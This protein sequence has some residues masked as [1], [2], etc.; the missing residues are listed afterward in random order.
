MLVLSEPNGRVAKALSSFPFRPSA[1]SSLFLLIVII[2]TILSGLYY[3]F[4]ASDRF[5]VET[6][7]IVRSV[8]GSQTGGLSAL[9]RTFGIMRAEDELYAVIDFLQSRDAA[10]AADEAVSLRQIWGR[11]EV[12]RIARYP[13]W[14]NFWRE[15]NFELVYEYYLDRVE[16]WYQDRGGIITLRVNAFTP[17]DAQ[18]L[19]KSLLQ[20][21]EKLINRMNERANKDAVS[22]AEKELNRAKAMVVDAQQKITNFRNE[23]LMLDPLAD[24]GKDP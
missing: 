15:E 7:F 23:E 1:V 3:F 18:L 24:L 21:S 13:R 8:R 4:I 20:Q 11:R 17:E 16:A 12:D 6:N 9:F 19:A 10:R 14:W 5:V 22:V 2:P